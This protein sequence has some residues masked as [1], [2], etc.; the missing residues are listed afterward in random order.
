[1]RYVD[2]VEEY[3]L[4][5]GNLTHSPNYF[6]IQEA[7][8]TE[9]LF[10]TKKSKKNKRESANTEGSYG[11]S[12]VSKRQREKRE[13]QVKKEQ[14]KEA[15]EALKGTDFYVVANFFAPFAPGP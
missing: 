13:R 14:E 12:R 11:G 9:L 10:L 7:R 15:A 8:I 6:R 2:A 3:S 4:S 5:S 1:M